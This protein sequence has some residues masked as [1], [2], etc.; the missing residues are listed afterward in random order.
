LA[1]VAY[2][3]FH[4]RPD[5]GDIVACTWQRTVAGAGRQRVVPDGCVDLV[6]RGGKLSVAG[7]DTGAWMSPVDPGAAIVGLRFRPGAA[8]TALGLPASELR[9]LRVALEDLWGPAACE[10]AERLREAAD[11]G[12]Q[13]GILERAIV[14]RRAAMDEPD[15][16]VLAATR[17][18]GGPGSRERVVG[19]R[20]GLSDRQ[21]LRRF[22]AAVGYG[23]KTLDRVL[24]FQRFLAR[25]RAVAGGEDSLARLA[26]ELGYAD[27]A[28]LT[29]A[30]VD[31]SGL[32]PRALAHAPQRAER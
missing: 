7:P 15:R 20:V 8:G 17:A 30:C 23:P 29:R 5:L 10:L 21:L 27:Q 4:P 11:A 12:A 16:L 32:T 1:A 6:W 28:H 19:K 24:R 2:R 18:L 26:A 9:D 13:R 14:A 25:G 31:L 22:R 3:E